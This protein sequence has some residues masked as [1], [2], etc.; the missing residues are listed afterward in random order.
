MFLDKNKNRESGKREN[1]ELEF[2]IFKTGG[3]KTVEFREK[4]DLLTWLNWTG[5]LPA[6][7]L[8]FAIHPLPYGYYILLRLVV[9]GCSIVYAVV[10]W[11]FFKP[12]AILSGILALLFNPLIPIYMDKEAWIVIDMIA[13]VYLF[14]AWRLLFLKIKKEQ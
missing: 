5:L 13:A 11:H 4:K 6:G 12:V 7:M 8:L 10:G 1:Y 14:I 9:C 2:L 3:N